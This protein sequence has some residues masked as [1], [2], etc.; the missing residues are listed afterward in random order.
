M[1]SRVFYRVVCGLFVLGLVGPGTARG[2]FPKKV[3]ALGK[4]HSFNAERVNVI[5]GPGQG[6]VFKLGEKAV[7]TYRAEGG[8]ELVMPQLAVRFRATLDRRGN[9]T[10]PVSK[11]TVF[12][13]K[14]F[15]QP[16]VEVAPP[17]SDE[18]P[19]GEKDGDN[20]KQPAAAPAEDEAP[21]A[22]SF[23]A[24]MQQAQGGEKELTEGVEYQVI[25]VL[26]NYRRGKF[27]VDCGEAGKLRGEVAEDC[28]VTV[29]LEGLPAL[30]AAK[31]GDEVV[32]E[33]YTSTPGEANARKIEITRA[34][35]DED[36]NTKKPARRTSRR[37]AETDEAK[38]ADEENPGFGR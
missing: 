2:D 29:E 4:L 32:A 7:V 6:W 14:V 12:T 37:S 15:F 36:E 26:A 1:P 27:V 17:E 30:K 31:P 5:T 8:P 3:D 24:A 21:A 10:A 28:A 22:E 16:L 38:P 33:G 35:P 18:K 23:D 34:T 13:P 9:L 25:G 20:G 19:A 11:L